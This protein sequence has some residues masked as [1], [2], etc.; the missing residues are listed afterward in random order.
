MS[1]RVTQQ[2]LFQTS[3]VVSRWGGLGVPGSEIPVSGDDGASPLADDGLNPSSE[4]RLVTT[5]LPSQGSLTVYPD[6]SV[7]FDASLAQDGVYTWVFTAYEDSISYGSETVT[8]PV[9][10]V[11][12]LLSPTSDISKGGWVSSSGA[13][14]Y[15]TLD[16]SAASDSDYIESTTPT[17]CEMLLAS[18]SDPNT[19]TDHILR[20]RLLAGSGGITVALRQGS[21]V[22]AT[23]GPHQLTSSPQDFEQTLTG[24][25]ADSITNYADLRVAFTSNQP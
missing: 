12:Q 15:Q 23:W 20:Y 11:G 25:Q 18:A 22:I 19:N 13:D 16:E 14:L 6:T 7:K 9:G 5:S 10:I 4:Y 1:H 3:H 17:T 21:T 24:I 8:F 2:Q